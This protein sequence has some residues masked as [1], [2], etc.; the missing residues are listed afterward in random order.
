MNKLQKYLQ[1]N[2][3][4]IL[5]PPDP[6]FSFN[7]RIDKCSNVFERQKVFKDYYDYNYAEIMR[8]AVTGHWFDSYGIDFTKYFTPIE[9]DAWCVIRAKKVILYPQFPV[10]NYF[11]DFGNPYLKIGLETDGKNFHDPVKDKIRDT[12]L[13]KDGW[14]IFRVSGSEANRIIEIPDPSY[15][16]E[17]YE[18][19]KRLELNT[20][21]EGVIEAL[22]QVYFRKKDKIDY[23]YY[24]ECITCLNNHRLADFEIS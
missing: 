7:E 3:P 10:L 17:D 2:P 1:E 5:P 22:Y 18:E 24:G 16:Q 15:S 4:K 12:N 23:Q 8:R 14:K 9:Y 6:R 13:L 20:T 11:L 21:V 19:A